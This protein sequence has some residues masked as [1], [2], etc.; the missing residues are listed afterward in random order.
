MNNTMDLSTS[1]QLDRLSAFCDGEL[2]E[3]ELN[4]VLDSL[5]ERCCA[6][7]KSYQII[8]DV[9]RDSSLA[10]STS[11]LFSLRLAK[12]LDAEPAHSLD[13]AEE[14]DTFQATGTYG[15]V[16]GVSPKGQIAQVHRMPGKPKAR[17]AFV[18]GGVAAAFATIVTFHIFQSNEIQ[19]GLDSTV[20]VLASAE[21]QPVVPVDTPE[22]TIE[23][24]VLAAT[25]VSNAADSSQ[26]FSRS[27]TVAVRASATN[28]RVSTEERRRTY[29]EYL[30]SHSDMSAHTPFMQVNY[31]VLGAGQ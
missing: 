6:E 12:A 29:P 7:I 2:S 23:S 3:S 28:S 22:V 16:S 14:Q 13:A 24:P 10:I 30:R 11:D 1:D 9:M 19:P 25:A 8:G 26:S 21:V 20:P 31:Q 18:A 17:L 27:P 15:A 5:D 4:F